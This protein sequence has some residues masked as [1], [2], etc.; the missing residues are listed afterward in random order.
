MYTKLYRSTCYH[1][2]LR[3]TV[4]QRT[5]TQYLQH[6]QMPS[7]SKKYLMYRTNWSARLITTAKWQKNIKTPLP[8]PTLLAIG[9]GGLTAAL[10]SAG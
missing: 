10:S 2:Q 5:F 6:R 8:F 9:L 3:N 4:I 7:A 1:Q